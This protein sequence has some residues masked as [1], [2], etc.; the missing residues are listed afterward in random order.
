M[1]SGEPGVIINKGTIKIITI[2]RELVITTEEPV[3][4]NKAIK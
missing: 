4:I 2:I 3:I 1:R